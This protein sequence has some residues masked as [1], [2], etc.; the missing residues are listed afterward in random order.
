M[1]GSPLMTKRTPTRTSPGPGTALSS[2]SPS[3]KPPTARQ[4]VRPYISTLIYPLV[5]ALTYIPSCIYPLKFTLSH[6]P[7]FMSTFWYL[8]HYNVVRHTS[9][10]L[11]HLVISPLTPFSPS[12]LYPCLFQV[13]MLEK[14]IKDVQ[15]QKLELSASMGGTVSQ[16]GGLIAMI[17]WLLWLKHINYHTIYH[18]LYH[19]FLCHVSSL[20]FI[21]VSPATPS[22]TSTIPISQDDRRS[23]NLSKSWML[24][25]LCSNPRKKCFIT[26][27]WYARTHIIFLDHFST[28]QYNL[29]YTC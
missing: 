17:D 5:C 23:S 25:M 11:L 14:Q 26:R 24:P 28:I 10:N 18:T 4:Q 1:K 19:T 3:N 20:T 9:P 22:I 29:Q 27:S 13:K 15:R 2:T 8:H 6:I 12:L 16:R 7:S 21:P